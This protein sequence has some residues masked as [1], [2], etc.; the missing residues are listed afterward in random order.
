MN[1]GLLFILSAPSGAGKTT[2]CKEVFTLMPQLRFSISY[3]TRAKRE[4]EQEA[5][6]YFF[7]TKEEFKQMVADNQFLEWAEVHGSLYGTPEAPLLE[8]IDRGRSAL[9]VLDVQG[10]SQ[11][12]DTVSSDILCGI[13]ILSPGEDEL[14]RRLRERGDSP[15]DIRK[16]IRTI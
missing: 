6:D 2:L 7:V 13:F 14:R 1:N 8:A 3:T 4:N 10:Y 5:R 11:V 9:M 16:R 15:K 12:R